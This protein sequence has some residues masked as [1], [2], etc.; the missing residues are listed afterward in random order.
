[1]YSTQE[2]SKPVRH[3][4]DALAAACGYFGRYLAD[5]ARWCRA[6]RRQ[7]LRR[8]CITPRADRPGGRLLPDAGDATRLRAEC[9]GGRARPAGA[10]A[11][12]RQRRGNQLLVRHVPALGPAPIPA[13]SPTADYVAGLGRLV[14]VL[15]VLYVVGAVM[16]GLLFYVMSWTGQHVLQGPARRVSSQHLHELSLSYYAEHEAGAVMSRI[17][18]DMDTIQQAIQLCA[19]QRARRRPAARLDRRSTCCGISVPYALI[20][21]A[22]VP[23][24]VAGDRAGSPARRARRSGARASGDRQRQRRAAGKH[25]RRARGAGLRPRGREHREL[26]RSRT[27]PTATPTSARWRSPRRWRRPWRRWATWRS[28]SSPSRAA[29]SCC[30]A[31]PSSAPPIS[32]GL[33]ITFLRLRP[34][35]Q[36]ADPA[37]R[38][39]VDQ[40]AERHRRRRAHLRPARRR[41]PTSQDK[42]TRRAMPPIAGRVEFDHVDAAYKEG[43]PVLCDVSFAAEPGQTIAIVGPTGAGKTTII[44]LIPRFYDVTGGAVQIDGIDV[45]DVTRPACAGRSASCCRTPSCSATR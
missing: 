19:G 40:P 33:V 11:E 45:R 15:V 29:W 42:P 30:A 25:R 27:P 10:A 14:L 34:A 2:T 23:V 32:L 38:R 18:N 13:E 8:R 21:L 44:N 26:P 17:T 20:S 7:H 22:V 9:A 16:S 3:Q 6:D 31:R 35:L 12:A 1:M 43:E 36:P 39:A 4:R 37:D 5:A 28:P 24:M 41:C